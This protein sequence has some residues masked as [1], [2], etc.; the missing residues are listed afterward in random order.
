MKPILSDSI[1]CFSL[2]TRHHFAVFLDPMETI[3]WLPTLRRNGVQAAYAYGHFLGS[4]LWRLCKCTLDKRKRFFEPGM[5]ARKA[6]SW[7]QQKTASGPLSIHGALGTMTLWCRQSQ[8]ELGR[9]LL[10]SCRLLSSNLPQV[11]PS[12]IRPGDRSSI[13]MVRTLISLHTSRRFTAITRNPSRRRSSWRR[14]MSLIT[15]TFR[16]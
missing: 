7:Q 6:H 11:H 3:G 1:I 14:A 10:G 8:K 5:R 12:T 2:A 13:S 16:R 4:S 15:V 9:Q